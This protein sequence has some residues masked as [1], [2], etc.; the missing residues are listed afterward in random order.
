MH[1]VRNIGLCTKDCLCLYVCPTGATDTETGQ[2][3]AE[4]CLSGCRNCVD[5][6]PSHAISLVPEIFPAQQ[7]KT[8]AVRK[9]LRILAESKSI[10]EKA[11]A[12]IARTAASPV[13]K[14]LARALE[15]SNRLMTEDLLR[16][17]GYMLPQ[18]PDVRALL[19]AL[20]DGKQPE[21]FPKE[22]AEKLLS[23]LQSG[24]GRVSG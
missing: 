14:Q 12:D 5:A 20:V 2:I 1:A 6:C 22:A 8:D 18:S 21:G 19:R 10:Q 23:L 17:A 16:E 13:I 15:K 24:E 11:A 9:A 4:K 7:E 3:D